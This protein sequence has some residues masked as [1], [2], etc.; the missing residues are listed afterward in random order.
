MQKILNQVKKNLQKL[1][2]TAKTPK[3]TK[4]LYLYLRSVTEKFYNVA[5]QATS[6]SFFV[7]ILNNKLK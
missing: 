4:A 6:M 3:D 2:K 1:N 7:R 5:N